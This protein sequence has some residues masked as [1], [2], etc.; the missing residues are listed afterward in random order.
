MTVGLTTQCIEATSGETQEEPGPETSHSAQILQGSHTPLASML[1][2]TPLAGSAQNLQAP[3]AAGNVQDRLDSYQAAITPADSG[4]ALPAQPRIHW[5]QSS[6]RA[7]RKQ[8]DEDVD[9]I[10]EGT[11][12]GDVERRLETMVTIIVSIAAEQFG[13]MDVKPEPS[14]TLSLYY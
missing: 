3:T 14:S 11:A 13:T 10:L 8:F 7:E 12:K 5:P 6:K 2:A 9:Q 1:P 4:G